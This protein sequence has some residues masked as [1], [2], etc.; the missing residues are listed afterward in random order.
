MKNLKEIQRK[1]LY[2]VWKAL[3]EFHPQKE[4]TTDQC[5]SK[6]ILYILEWVR[7]KLGD[8]CPE[9]IASVPAK[10]DYRRFDFRAQKPLKYRE[11][12][13]LRIL[14]WNENWTLRL[15]E[16]NEGFPGEFIVN[17]SFKRQEDSVLFAMKTECR[18]SLDAPT[19]SA[20]RPGYIRDLLNDPDFFMTEPGLSE[21][22][23]LSYDPIEVSGKSRNDIDGFCREFVK[24]P[25]RNMPILFYPEP[26]NEED[27][28]K[29]RSVSAKLMGYFYVAVIRGSVRKL[30]CENMP[31]ESEVY[32]EVL[33]AGNALLHTDNGAS[34]EEEFE[35]RAEL[36]PLTDEFE[37]LI[38]NYRY[39]EPLTRDCDFRDIIF[40]A[41]L[42]GEY[43]RDVIRSAESG[44]DREAYIGELLRQNTDQEERIAQ[45]QTEKGE[46]SEE[47]GKLRKELAQKD[48]SILNMQRD[49][50]RY[51][52]KN[53]KLT[54]D[55][56]QQEEKA[57][58][59]KQDM[60]DRLDNSADLLT[61]VQRQGALIAKSFSLL[62]GRDEREKLVRWIRFFYE[63]ELILHERAEKSILD[64]KAKNRD[65]EDICKG[66]HFVAGFTRLMRIDGMTPEKANRLA[67]KTFDFDRNNFEITNS[68]SKETRDRYLSDYQVD[69]REY[70]PGDPDPRYGA[71]ELE[72][73]L[74]RADRGIVPKYR[75]YFLY[76]GGLKK[77]VIGYMPDHL[78]TFKYNG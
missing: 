9:E 29:L 65:W 52:R 16:E 54:E 67:G 50:D 53:Q 46:M 35:K 22:Y 36:F 69:L 64:D 44:E 61:Q 12:L 48:K 17:L 10:E 38:V 15:V 37:T 49:L 60:Q 1:R 45:V 6:V 8:A 39:I 56:A 34:E 32:K 2:P 63:D 59:E 40:N 5:M 43:M 28:E 27:E 58:T 31:M 62:E 4:L 57:E 11:P 23:R 18:Q 71:M 13:E 55:K 41:D 19:A 14:F 26:Q 21:K 20:Y 7:G 66:I 72:Y 42:W 25:G 51:E 24:A 73:H 76:D 78:R 77:S 75:I 74:Q 68:M 3:L 47:I 33:E 70:H 30:F